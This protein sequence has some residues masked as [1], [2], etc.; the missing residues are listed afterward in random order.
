M[1][2]LVRSGGRTPIQLVPVPVSLLCAAQL[3]LTSTGHKAG[4]KEHV[5]NT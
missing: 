2:Q 4:A 1:A 3:S 5:T